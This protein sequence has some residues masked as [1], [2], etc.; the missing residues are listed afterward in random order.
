MT[1]QQ[2]RELVRFCLAA[3]SPYYQS[4]HKRNLFQ[5]GLLPLDFR[6]ALA[7]NDR[8]LRW[9]VAVAY[10]QAGQFLPSNIVD[11]H[12]F[13]AYYFNLGHEFSNSERIAEAAAML[14]PEFQSQRVVLEGL[15]VCRDIDVD[16]I[17]G[18]MALPSETVQIFE[19]LF[20]NLRDRLDDSA[21]IAS[22]VYPQTRFE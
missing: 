20:F 18:L 5:Q 10:A 4:A 19:K 15:L 22:I 21:Y 12:I 1:S 7:L 3:D 16:G 9:N 2:I 8:K 6:L 11:L 13:N 14:H 17:A